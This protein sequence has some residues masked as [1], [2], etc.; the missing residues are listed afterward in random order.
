MYFFIVDID[1][2][3]AKEEKEVRNAKN[4]KEA[5]DQEKMC[6]Q[7]LKLDRRV[8]TLAEIAHFVRCIPFSSD[9]NSEIWSSP[10]SITT[11]KQGSPL[12][13][14]LLMVQFIFPLTKE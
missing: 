10:N 5:E 13:H 12:D 7:R 14:S 4:A 2:E 6:I 3:D 11:M 9:R 8:R 1:A